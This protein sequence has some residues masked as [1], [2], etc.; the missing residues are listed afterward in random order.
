MR[1]QAFW[2]GAA[3]GAWVIFA[4]PYLL[5]LDASITLISVYVGLTSLGPLII[6]PIAAANLRNRAQ[7]RRWM[8]ICGVISR[9]FFFMPAVAL[10]FGDLKAEVAILMFCLCAMPTIVFGALWSPTPGV[11]VEAEHQPMIVNARVR[12]ANIGA[13]S[14]NGA[15]GLGMI[16]LP[17]PFNYVALF[18]ISGSLGLAEMYVISRIIY[19]DSPEAYLDSFKE[20][21][22]VKKIR[23]ERKFFYFLFGIG[24]IVSASS[25]AGPLQS[26]YFINDRGVSDRWLGIWA[27]A[28]SVGAV[29]GTLIWRKLQTTHGSYAIFSWTVP[30]SGIYFLLIIL[31]PNVELI[32]IATLFAG[33]MNA[34]TD[35]GIWL[36][37]FRYGSEERRTM[38]INIYVGVA[39]GIPFIAA[40]FIPFLTNRF[41]LTEIFIVSFIIRTLVGLYFKIPSIYALLRDDAPNKSDQ[42]RDEMKRNDE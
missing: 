26:V 32:L 18:V 5:R 4:I 24:L 30:I 35:T 13:L 40:F 17:F 14:A 3:N 6:G 9:I 38:L 27:M 34:G 23:A 19:P 1:L 16:F 29:F 2:G 12:I 20:H 25:I 41:T 22:D 31:A 37:L 39:L 42:L 33:W 7:Q 11:V 21:F 10:F 8:L 28:L 36:G 15:I